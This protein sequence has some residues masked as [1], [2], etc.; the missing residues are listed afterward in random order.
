MNQSLK[1]KNNDWKRGILGTIQFLIDSGLSNKL[2]CN[3]G[4][5][6]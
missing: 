2:K 3:A 1:I 5:H 6:C 4:D